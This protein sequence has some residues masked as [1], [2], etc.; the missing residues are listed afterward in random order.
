MAIK[1]VLIVVGLKLACIVI[2]PREK[3]EIWDL[4]ALHRFQVGNNKSEAL[5]NNDENHS[6][7]E[8]KDKG[9]SP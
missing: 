3:Q 8:Q 2:V 9:H 7:I 5:D 1:K 4:M 6:L